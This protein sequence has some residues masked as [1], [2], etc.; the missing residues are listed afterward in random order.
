MD[1]RVDRTPA[2]IGRFSYEGLDRVMHEKAR[3]AFCRPWPWM[4]EECCSTTW[5]S[6]A[7]WRMEILTGIWSC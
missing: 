4:R 2:S 6:F 1:D 5:S 7:H 3:L